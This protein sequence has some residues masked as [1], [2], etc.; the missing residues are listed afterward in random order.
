MLVATFSN[1]WSPGFSRVNGAGR[2]PPA[3]DSEQQDGNGAA[4]TQTR[5]ELQRLR[6][7]GRAGQ[8]AEVYPDQKQQDDEDDR[9]E[10][11][12]PR[13]YGGG[14]PD[15]VGRRGSTSVTDDGFVGYL[16]PATPALHQLDRTLPVTSTSTTRRP[17]HRATRPT[18]AALVFFRISNGRTAAM[19]VSTTPNVHTI[20]APVGR[21]RTSDR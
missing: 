16:G 19:R 2:S 14:L 13:R 18:T 21:S 4:R 8:V 12:P 20:V 6:I 7:G 5:R 17:A 15:R 3:N 10:R 11:A 9:H 1:G